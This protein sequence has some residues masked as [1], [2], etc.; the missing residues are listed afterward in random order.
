MFKLVSNV[1]IP[2][3]RG[4]APL[5]AQYASFPALPAGQKPIFKY[6]EAKEVFNADRAKQL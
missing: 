2:S 3:F 4:A 1:V 6:A 5:G